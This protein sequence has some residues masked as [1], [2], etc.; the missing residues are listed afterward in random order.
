[1]I[2]AR[3][4][5][6]FAPVCRYV[7][8]KPWSYSSRSGNWMLVKHLLPAFQLLKDA[9]KLFEADRRVTC[10]AIIIVSPRV[11]TSV[12]HKSKSKSKSDADVDVVR[13]LFLHE[14][15]FH[16]NNNMEVT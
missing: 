8:G 1:M 6:L 9:T 7:F 14:L 16:V 15:S 12:R 13:N 3:R 4:T 2:H 5:L 11:F 10:T